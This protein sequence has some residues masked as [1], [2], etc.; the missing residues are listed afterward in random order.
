MLGRARQAGVRRFLTIG[1]DEATSA[2]AVTLARERRG[3]RAAIGVHPGRVGGLDLKQMLARLRPLAGQ[4]R[5]VAVGE[6][7]LDETSRAS[8]ADQEAFF[9]AFIELALEQQLALSL[10]VI[11]RHRRAQHLLGR[12]GAGRAVV[13]YFQGDAELAAAYLEIGCFISLGKP[14]TLPERGALREAA[15][16]IPL[17]RLLLE[18]DTYPLPGRATEPRDVATICQTIATLRALSFDEVATATT[19]NFA[20]L[21]GK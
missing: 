9:A 15:R 16:R 18:T 8:A 1:V 20:R 13:H 4:P 14:V 10:H 3:V 5:V 21:F 19:Q 11:G 17:D 12:G 2:A 6:V 7:G